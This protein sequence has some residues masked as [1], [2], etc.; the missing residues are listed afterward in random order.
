MVLSSGTSR[1]MASKVSGVMSKSA[2]RA[3]AGMCSRLLV[4]PPVA[5]I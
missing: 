5:I 4:L 2:C 3:S 1:L